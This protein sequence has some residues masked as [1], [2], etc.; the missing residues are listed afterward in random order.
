MLVK[1]ETIISDTTCHDNST[2]AIQRVE[3]VSKRVTA[4]HTEL[5]SKEESLLALGPNFAVTPIINEGFM[6]DV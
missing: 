4:I 5:S 1:Y 2:I 3:S 6:D